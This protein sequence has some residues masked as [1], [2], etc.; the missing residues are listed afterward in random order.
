MKKPTNSN[1]S[2]QRSTNVKTRKVANQ[3]NTTALSDPMNPLQNTYLKEKRINMIINFL[4][5]NNYQNNYSKKDFIN[6]TIDFRPILKFIMEKLDPN[7]NLL[8]S[9]TEDKIEALAK[10][11]EYPGKLNKNFIRDFNTP[12]NFLYI[13]TFIC[14]MA[15]LCSYKDNFINNEIN[16]KFYKTEKNI[17]SSSPLSENNDNINLDDKKE[18]YEFLDECIKSLNNTENA[19]NNQTINDVIEK[20]KNKFNTLCNEELNKIEQN[21]AEYEKLEKENKIMESQLPLIDTIKSEENE[22]LQKLNSTKTEYEQ[23]KEDINLFNQ[24]LIDISNN[25]TE[26]EQK[27][28]LLENDIKSTRNIIDTQIMSRAE[29]D[30]Q[31]E[32]NNNIL[33]KIE[34]IKKDI[35]VLKNTKNDI[36]NT[37]QSLINKLTIIA[38]DI[39]N[40]DINNT[41]TIKNLN[42][43]NNNINS[44]DKNNNDISYLLNMT[45]IN[46]EIKNNIINNEVYKNKELLD[47]YDQIILKYKSYITD[48][49]NDYNSNIISNNELSK[50]KEIIR[51]EIDKYNNYLIND[52][53]INEQQKEMMN[54]LNNDFLKYNKENSDYINIIN[55][56]VKI[57]ENNIEDKKQKLIDKE[58]EYNNLKLQFDDFKNETYELINALSERYNLYYNNFIDFSNEIT[59]KIVNCNQKLK[60]ICDSLPKKENNDSEKK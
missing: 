52:N 53:Q 2:K 27:L 8:E 33:N 25:I 28:N 5:Q 32:E 3:Y 54:R 7:M 42:N 20:Y 10:I 29:Y 51:T 41:K 18:Y 1:L 49:K 55:N 48:I 15:N 36:I 17:C 50:N 12:S 4:S 59:N 38:N 43:I 57:Y 45:F 56:D 47:K 58:N 19:D 9:Q 16:N 11:Y 37:N 31:Q 26:Q 22:M 13:L 44:N 21:F 6:M 46:K 23:S 60:N 39:N 14:Y 35:N 24:N 34:M 30:I 40:I